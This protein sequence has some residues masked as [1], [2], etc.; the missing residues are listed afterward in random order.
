MSKKIYLG[1][2]CAYTKKIKSTKNIDVPKLLRIMNEFTGRDIEEL[3]KE[4]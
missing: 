3:I 2:L 4:Y 1:G